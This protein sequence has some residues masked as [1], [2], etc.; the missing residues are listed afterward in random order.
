[1]KKIIIVLVLFTSI[2]TQAQQVW[3]RDKGKFY[4]QIGGTIYYYDSKINLDNS[5]TAI[6]RKVTGNAIQAY[7]EYGITDKLTFNTVVPFVLSD[8]KNTAATQPIG[9]SDGSLNAFG[10]IN[11]GLTYNFYK[12]NGY[13]IS[14]KLLS[15]LPTATF[16]ENTGLRTGTDAFGIAPSFLV[17]YG[18]NSFFA[19]AEL[20]LN[21]RTNKYSSQTIGGF[22]IGKSFGASKKLLIIFHTDI[23]SSNYDGKY[24]DKNSI[25]TVTYLNNQTYFAHG[26]KFG[27]K[28]NENLMAWGDIRAGSYTANLGTNSSP[29]PGFSFAISY[30]N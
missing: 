13:V 19:S 8:S 7:L 3:T 29:V 18:G 4:S 6:D 12:K 1:M 24:D 23:Q 30:S 11:L 22:Q 20:G 16:K 10:N 21:Y 5:I 14:A 2:C 9:L 28:L 15:A 26:F 27:Y 25:Y 17:G